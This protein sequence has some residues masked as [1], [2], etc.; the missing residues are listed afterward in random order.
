MP[1]PKSYIVEL[2][3]MGAPSLV[4]GPILIS[5]ALQ[6]LLELNAHEL[7]PGL[8]LDAGDDEGE[9]LIPHLL[10]QP[11]QP[12]LEKDLGRG[13][14]WLRRGWSRRQVEWVG[15]G[16]MEGLEIELDG[17][18]AWKGWWMGWME[19]MS[20]ELDGNVNGC[21]RLDVE[22]MWRLDRRTGHCIEW[23]GWTLDRMEGLDGR[24]GYWVGWMKC[25]LP[26]GQKTD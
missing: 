25:W 7:A 21:V 1:P 6:N 4:G 11:Q 16:W 5:P 24:V 20:D 2:G 12:S 23:K 19:R 22:E 17:R 10:Q 9:A 14:R 3:H 26:E 8:S 15:L 13:R 18:A